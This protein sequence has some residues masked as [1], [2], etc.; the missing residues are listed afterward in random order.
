MVTWTTSP[1][2]R[3]IPLSCFNRHIHMNSRRGATKICCKELNCGK[4]GVTSSTR[5]RLYRTQSRLY[6][7]QHLLALAADWKLAN[8]LARQSSALA[9]SPPCAVTFQTVC[10]WFPSGRCRTTI[11]HIADSLISTADPGSIS[12]TL[13]MRRRIPVWVEF[14]ERRV[15]RGLHMEKGIRQKMPQSEH[16][17]G[18]SC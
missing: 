7:Y 8:V 1:L 12:R 11:D 5:N 14:I 9:R 3:N 13:R 10:R 17:I 18:T 15:R 2:M 6:L 4:C 16:C